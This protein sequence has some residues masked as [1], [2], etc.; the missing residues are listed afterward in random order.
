MICLQAKLN[1]IKALGMKNGRKWQIW[2]KNKEAAAG[3]ACD[4]IGLVRIADIDDQAGQASDKGI[5]RS[6]R[7][8]AR[9]KR[10]FLIIR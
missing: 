9:I 4:F 6:Q 1:K 10:G 2:L 5:A 3:I 8:M 7:N